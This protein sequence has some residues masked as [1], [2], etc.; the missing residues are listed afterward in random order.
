MTPLADQADVPVAPA[1]SASWWLRLGQAVMFVGLLAIATILAAGKNTPWPAYVIAGVLL[2]LFI[3][4]LVIVDRLAPLGRGVWVGLL[5]LGAVALMA[6]SPDFLWIAFPLW[7]L[8]GAVLPLF[9]SLLFTA[10]TLA[11]IV[12]VL[13]MAGGESVGA[14]LGPLVGALIAIGLSRGVLMFEHEA[15]E[16]RRLLGE[17]LRAE[18]E[19]ALAQREAGVL[20]ERTRLAHDIHDT[21]AQGFSSLLLLARAAQRDPDGASGLLA[22]IEA[23]AAENLAESRRVIYALMPDAA[24]AGGLEAPLRR[25]ARETADAIGAEASVVV[26]PDLPRLS[27]GS[28]VALLR[29][30]QG[31]LANVRLHSAATRVAVELTRSDDAVLL[32]IVDDGVGFDL[33]GLPA[34]S[35]DGGYGLRA[36]RERLTALGGGLTVESEPGGGTALSVRLPLVVAS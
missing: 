10:V 36:L 29:A 8:A 27:T 5:F 2:V 33:A 14:V 34:A 20:A 18:E 24:G 1:W 28:E 23:T 26:D 25:L 3:G 12:T 35:L 9:V 13:T 11:V 19:T 15:S 31:G 30:A 16:H 22:Q 17:V 6:L 4:G 7:M 21:L 32:D